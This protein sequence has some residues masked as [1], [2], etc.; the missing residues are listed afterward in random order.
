VLGIATRAA[1][2]GRSFRTPASL[3]LAIAALTQFVYPYLY[4]ALLLLDPFMLVVLTLRNGL[5]FVL[6]G[7]AIHAIV[8]APKA[9]SVDEDLDGEWLPALLPRSGAG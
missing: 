4:R 9:S 3:V 8:T 6:L 7:W 1:G 5:Y 2:H